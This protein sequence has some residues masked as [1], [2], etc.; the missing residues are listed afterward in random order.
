MKIRNNKNY[1]KKSSFLSVSMFCSNWDQSH[2]LWTVVDIGVEHPLGTDNQHM[3]QSITTD[4]CTLGQVITF[5]NLQI[6]L[7]FTFLFFHLPSITTPT[8]N[9]FF[10]LSI[11][12]YN[13]Q[14]CK[15]SVYLTLYSILHEHGN[16]LV[17][18]LSMLQINPLYL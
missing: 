10:F 6:F 2:S 17:L 13:W 7:L 3:L 5:L 9:W 11:S 18:I 16:I 1:R 14:N 15:F 12:G 4:H 8:Q